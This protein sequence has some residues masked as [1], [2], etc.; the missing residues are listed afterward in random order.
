MARHLK[1]AAAQLGPLHLADT[2]E[3]A[4]ARLLAICCAKR[5]AWARSSSCFPSS[6]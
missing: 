6:R 4:V 3:A 5:T 1:I 2:R